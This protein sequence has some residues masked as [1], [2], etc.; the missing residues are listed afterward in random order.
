MV[1][2]GGVEKGVGRR[3]EKGKGEERGGSYTLTIK[4]DLMM[5]VIPILVLYCR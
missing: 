4:I 3:R 1:E 5:L 2:M